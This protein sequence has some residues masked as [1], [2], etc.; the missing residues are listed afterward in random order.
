M[1][2]ASNAS[3]SN[4]SKDAVSKI[5]EHFSGELGYS[6][7]KNIFKCVS[8]IGGKIKV[9]DFWE[10]DS[11]SGSLYVRSVGDFDIFIPGHTSAE[12]DT[13]TVAHELGHY[14]LHFLFKKDSVN[15]P[16]KADRYGTG[17]VEWEANWFAAAF[18][19]P[20]A[21]FD[22]AYRTAQGSL[23]VVAKEFGVSEEAAKVRASSLGLT[24]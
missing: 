24:R 10:S 7:N 6:K 1:A 23:A 18:L 8:K 17:R 22:Q 21:K 14:V 4:L 19:M 9:K 13:F 5:A 20:A 12:R 3:P 16:L 2:Q 15:V 11:K